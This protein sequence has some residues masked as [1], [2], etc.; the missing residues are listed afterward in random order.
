MIMLGLD[1]VRDII[2]AAGSEMFLLLL[3]LLIVTVVVGLSARTLFSTV[4]GLVNGEVT[5]LVS[6][7][8]QTV[9]N[10]RGTTKFINETAVSPIIRLYGFFAA[11]RRVVAV[12]LGLSSRRQREE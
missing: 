1:D 10:V 7:A 3:A 8:R 4:R 11:I 2:I 6:S 5:P 12:L 9:N